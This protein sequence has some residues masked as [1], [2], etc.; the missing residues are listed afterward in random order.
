MDKITVTD[1]DGKPVEVTVKPDGMYTFKQP[2]G[3]VKIEVTCK[4]IEAPWNNP[5]SDVSE[6]D[7]YYEAVR[8]VHER[9]LVNGYSDG[10]FG[11]NDALSRAQLAQ[12]LFNKEGRH[13]VDQLMD[14][15]DG[16]PAR[17]LRAAHRTVR[18]PEAGNTGTGSAN[19]EKFL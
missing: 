13:G 18:P 2:N 10:W 5:F 12:I 3:K 4:P 11:P 7:W 9:D 8:F 19:A 17:A 1:K 15:S 16:P 14:F 6:S